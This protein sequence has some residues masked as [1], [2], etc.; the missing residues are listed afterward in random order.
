MFLL[1][2]Y[3]KYYVY[4]HSQCI[5]NYPGYMSCKFQIISIHNKQVMVNYIE[6]LDLGALPHPRGIA[7]THWIWKHNVQFIPSG[8]D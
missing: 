5:A 1:A 2:G 7:P 6:G 4:K 3:F 8:D